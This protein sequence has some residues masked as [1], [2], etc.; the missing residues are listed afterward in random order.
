MARVSNPQQLSFPTAGSAGESPAEEL[1]A[2]GQ[3]ARGCRACPLWEIGTQ[4]VFGEGA[5]PAKLIVLG[6]APGRQEDQQGRPFVGPAGQLLDQA[7]RQAGLDRE[8]IYISNVVKHRPWLQEGRRQKNRPPRSS[9]I[10]ACRPWLEAE[11]RLVEPRLI[12]CLGAHAARAILGASFRLTQQRGEWQDVSTSVADGVSALATFH[13]SYVLI[14]PE[15]NRESLE[16]A[17]FADFRTVASR[18]ASVCTAR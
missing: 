5:V 10:K 12:V 17:F 15:P 18:L 2:V 14:Q 1:A 13:P 4:T 11:L 16:A 7:L 3:E 9:E 8:S 6:E